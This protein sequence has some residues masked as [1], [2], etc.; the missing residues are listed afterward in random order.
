MAAAQLNSHAAAIRAELHEGDKC[1]VCGG[2]YAQC[3]A[4]GDGDVEK[5]RAER[6]AAVKALKA[7]T[8]REAECAKRLDR[9]KSA[10]SH[11]TAERD[12]T[13]DLLSAA[14]NAAAQ[15]KVE[16]QVYAQLFGIRISSK[17]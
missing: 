16:P 2:T 4:V 12:K 13:K 3:A 9:E 6:D 10:Y 14:N 11:A 15:T 7:A 1:P 5:R 8:D 17:K